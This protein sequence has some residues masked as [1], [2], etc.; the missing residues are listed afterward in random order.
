[1]KAKESGKERFIRLATKRVNNTLKAIQLIGN[2]SNRNNYDYTDKH[3]DKIFGALSG[4]LK[5]CRERFQ[6]S[7]LK[8]KN[9]FTLE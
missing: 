6:A 5:N 3:V 9:G 1:V 7:G 4:E 8:S 2:L